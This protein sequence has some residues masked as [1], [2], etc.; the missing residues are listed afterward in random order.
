MYHNLLDRWD[1]RKARKGDHVKRERPFRLDIDLAFPGATHAETLDD[2]IRLAELASNDTEFFRPNAARDWH[3]DANEQ[4]LSFASGIQTETPEN[5][6][7]TTRI[8]TSKGADRALIVF[9][10]WNANARNNAL[11]KFLSRRGTAVFEM[12]MPYH[13][14]R[15][16]PGA[17][18]ADDMLGPS[19]GRTMRS[20]RQAVQD[21]RSLVRIARDLGYKDISLLGMSLGSWVAGLV[22]AQ[23]ELVS[24]AALF[25]TAGSLADMVWNGRA[26][27][28]IRASLEKEIS[29]AGLRHAWAPLNLEHHVTGLA[30]PDLALQIVLAK[31][32]RVVL[33]DISARF[34]DRLEEAGANVR[35]TYLN[36]GHYSL[37]LPPYNLRAG[38]SL[39][40]LLTVQD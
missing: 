18:Y 23:E 24:R 39:N 11:A 32:D 9:H 7:V 27:R 3:V 13:F 19:L 37:G 17:A 33:P 12:A 8:T 26:T 20:I 4:W 34:V 14:E 31:R 35:T 5:N 29:L 30:R 21:G 6:R 15:R 1:E 16:R 28:S 2:F 10:H 25:L 38:M 40:R 22:A 36:C